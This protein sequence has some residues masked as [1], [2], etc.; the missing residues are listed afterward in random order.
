MNTETT[1]TTISNDETVVM[2]PIDALRTK[3]EL[4]NRAMKWRSF[5]E[6]AQ[7]KQEKIAQTK[8][9]QDIQRQGQL[10][11]VIVYRRDAD[12]EDNDNGSPTYWLVSGHHRLLALRELGKKKI[13]AVIHVGDFKAMQVEAILCNMEIQMPLTARQRT[14]NAWFAL[15]HAD[16]TTFREMTRAQQ[17]RK[18]GVSLSTI[19]NMRRKMKEL[20]DDIKKKYA[21]EIYMKGDK[22]AWVILANSYP[23]WW[24]IKDDE[25]KRN[26]TIDFK[27]S[28]AMETERIENLL[29]I[30]DSESEVLSA[31]G[32]R[33]RE[34]AL[35][36]ILKKYTQTRLEQETMD[37][38]EENDD[39]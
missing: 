21:E 23:V 16:V 19:K 33:V 39:F 36:A 1:G 20:L 2:I 25:E 3:P 6:Q 4:Q 31:E 22:E 8:L 12:N 37:V 24:M 5:E 28:V 17:S 30:E 32:V 34:L 10:T 9:K 7:K 35:K 11:P 14:Q 15:T 38:D 18:L 26:N 29:R 13:K 27:H